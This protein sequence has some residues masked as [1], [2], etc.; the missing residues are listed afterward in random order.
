MCLTLSL[1]GIVCG[2][3]NWFRIQE[4]GNSIRVTAK[5]VTKRIMGSGR[6]SDQRVESV[7]TNKRFIQTQVQQT[8]LNTSYKHKLSRQN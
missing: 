6:E 7:G 1:N 8:E 2:S 5:M 4:D 3:E